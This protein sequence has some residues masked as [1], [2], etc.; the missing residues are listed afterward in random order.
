M[1]RGFFALVDDEDY[2][3]LNKFSWCEDGKGYAVRG[4]KKESGIGRTNIFMHRQIMGLKNGD[5]LCVDHI[6]ENGLNNCKS[7]LRKCTRNG[8]ARNIKLR[9]NNTSGYKGVTFFRRD[10]KWK[11]QIKTGE[12]ARH[13]GYFSTKEAAYEAYCTEA[14]KHFGEFA[15]LGDGCV[16]LKDKE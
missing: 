1:S 4:V 12:K 2:D 15:N 3:G 13:I 11:A 10:G 5:Q 7:N 16:I 14:K 6:D 8:N 9:S